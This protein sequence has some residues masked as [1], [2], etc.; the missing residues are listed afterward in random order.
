MFYIFYKRPICATYQFS[1][2]HF[3]ESFDQKSFPDS[4]R[5]RKIQFITECRC[6][7]EVI[8][9]CNRKYQVQLITQMKK[10]HH[11]EK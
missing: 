6:T 7:D 10:N 9:I 4:N 2:H 3:Y 11:S 1:S 5:S 8:H